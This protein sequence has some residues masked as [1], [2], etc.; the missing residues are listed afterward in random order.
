M[1]EAASDIAAVVQAETKGHM[2]V[3]QAGYDKVLIYADAPRGTAKRRFLG[4]GWIGFLN[5]TKQ[6][7]QVRD[8]SRGG[9]AVSTVVHEVKVGINPSG[10]LVASP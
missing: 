2:R 3:G 5:T 8:R 1:I 7:L 4:E 10:Q 9:T 6:T